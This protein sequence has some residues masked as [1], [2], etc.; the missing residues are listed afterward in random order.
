MSSMHTDSGDA[1]SSIRIGR[2]AKQSEV[3]VPED[4]WT[5]VTS[6]AMRKRLQNRLNQRAYSKDFLTNDDLPAV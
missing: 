5:G 2:M 3:L 1:L 6:A 4:D